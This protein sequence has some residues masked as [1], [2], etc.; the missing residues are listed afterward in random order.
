[1]YNRLPLP[2]IGRVCSFIPKIYVH[3]HDLFKVNIVS[4]K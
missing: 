4:T 3:L 2:P 1:M